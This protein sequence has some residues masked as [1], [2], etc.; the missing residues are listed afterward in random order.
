MEDG[1]SFAPG[2]SLWFGLFCP[3]PSSLNRPHPPHSQ[4]HRAFTARWLIRDALAMRERPGKLRG[5]SSYRCPFFPDIPPSMTPGSFRRFA[6]V[7]IQFSDAEHGLRQDVTSSALPSSCNPFRGG[8]HFGDILIQL[9][10]G[11]SVCAPSCDGTDQ[12][13]PAALVCN[14]S[15]PCI[16]TAPSKVMF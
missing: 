16:L 13:S 9:R 7:M 14:R 4:A 1:S 11:L 10:Y 15:V 6:I 5:V 8:P 12:V 3:D 2:F